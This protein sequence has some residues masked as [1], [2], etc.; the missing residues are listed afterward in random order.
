MNFQSNS[1]FELALRNLNPKSV[2]LY[3]PYL[4]F[5]RAI[6]IYNAERVK[7]PNND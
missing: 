1:E 7:F 2:I 5:M 4:E 6:E 3:E